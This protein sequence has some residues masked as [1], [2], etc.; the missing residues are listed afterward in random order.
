MTDIASP[1]SAARISATGT[2][3]RRT[4]PGRRSRPAPRARADRRVRLRAST[5]RVSPSPWS[6]ST[7]CGVTCAATKRCAASIR[8][9]S[10]GVGGFIRSG[11]SSGSLVKWVVGVSSRADSR[12]PSENRSPPW[13]VCSHHNDCPS[14]PNFT[15]PSRFRTTRMTWSMRSKM[16]VP[17]MKRP[18]NAA[19]AAE[20]KLL[21]LPKPATP[22]PPQDDAVLCL[23]YLD[24]GQRRVHCHPKVAARRH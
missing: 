17:P 1:K 5:E 10:A 23:K 7:T 16:A 9:C 24:D 6:Q 18:N 4:G 19:C 8:R 21:R 20:N 12:G 13:L 3:S 15:A 2:C 11:A 22:V 14:P